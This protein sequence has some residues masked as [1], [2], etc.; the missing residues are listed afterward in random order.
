[1]FEQV[2]PKIKQYCRYRERC[3]FEVKQKLFA[4]GLALKDV[5]VLLCRL[6]EEDILNEE[7]YAIQFA[8]GRFRLNKWGKVKI[9][10]ELRQKKVNEN[11]IKRALKEIEEP[12]Y[13][14]S[15]Q[16]LALTKWES[17]KA[18]HYIARQAKTIAYLHQKGYEGG[19]IQQVITR[20]R[21]KATE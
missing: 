4:M 16:K 2:Y 7:R 18:E 21:A 12:D 10:Y 5:E 17:L 3:H 19:I 15:L 13:E 8:G 9:V 6:I 11:I 20:I 14:A 1:M